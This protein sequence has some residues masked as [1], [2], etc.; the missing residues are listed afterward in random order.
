M[1]DF[2]VVHRS[3]T[4]IMQAPEVAAQTITFLR[5]GRFGTPGGE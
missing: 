2:T 4:F 3:H 1:T 5:T